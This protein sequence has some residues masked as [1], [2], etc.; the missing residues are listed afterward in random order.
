M[1]FKVSII[2]P[3]FNE[4]KTIGQCILQTYEVLNHSGLEYEIIVIDDGSKDE[5]FKIV[6]NIASSIKAI[7][8]IKHEKNLGKGEAI[9]TGLNVASG[10][11]I[12][13]ID[14]DLEYSPKDI[15]SLINPIIEGKANIVYG[16]RFLKNN[17]MNFF[18]RF[19]NILLTNIANIL[20]D[21]KLTDIM[22]GSKAFKK[23]FRKNLA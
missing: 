18:R 8:L 12:C 7:K 23:K 9:K 6:K 5:T 15:P 1:M 17:I 22:T 19:G 3:A 10:D 20:Y 13:I 16:S 4:E 14:A 11:I 2:V 21:L